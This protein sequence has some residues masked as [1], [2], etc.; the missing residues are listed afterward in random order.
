MIPQRGPGQSFEAHQAD[1]AAWMGCSVEALNAVH[2]PLH[3]EFCRWLG[4][5]SQ[6]LRDARG[7]ALS[8]RER[9]LASLEEMAVLTTQ[10]LIVA[11]GAWERAEPKEWR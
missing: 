9:Q 3:V 10:R 2:D 7:E 8:E 6:A 5:E 1:V 4:V 11:A